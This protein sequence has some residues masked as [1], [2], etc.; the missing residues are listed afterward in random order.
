MRT[1]VR[2]GGEGGFTLVEVI[3]ALFVLAVVIL[4]IIFVQTR[5]LVTNADSQARQAAT[6]AANQAMEELRAMPWDYLRRGLYSGWNA[7]GSDPFVTGADA[8]RVDGVDYDLIVGTTGADQDPA[9]FA[10]PPLFDD[11]GA[12]VQTLSSGSGNGAEIVLR[13]YTTDDINGQSG[14]V[15]LLVVASWDKVSNG[16]PELTVITST[17]YSPTGGCGDPTQSPF[18]ASCQ[19]SFEASAQTANVEIAAL[20]NNLT[21]GDASPILDGSIFHFMHVETGSTAARVTSQQVSNTSAFATSGGV[22]WDDD[23]LST[24]PA[25][26]GW[27]NGYSQFSVRASDDTT[28][29]ADPANP[30]IVTGTG[31]AST[32]AISAAPFTLNARSDESRSASVFA[33]TTTSCA[34]GLLLDVTPTAPCASSSLGAN[35]SGTGYMA[36]DIDGSVL[37]LARI[38]ASGLYSRDN[39][40]AARFATVAGNSSVKCQVVTGTDSGCVSAGAQQSVGD[41]V[42][43]AG[44]WDAAG[45]TDGLI[46]IDGYS[47]SALA[48][49]GVG[50][51]SESTAPSQLSRS[52]SISYWDGSG[53]SPLGAVPAGATA[54]ED[55]AAATWTLPGATITATGGVQVTEGVTKEAVPLNCQGDAGCTVSASNGLVIATV[56]YEIEPAGSSTFTA[57]A[58]TVKTYINGS[59][60]TTAYREAPDAP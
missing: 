6:A 25:S 11:T 24:A 36:L 5:A 58:L 27:V 55:I 18:L 7:S 32:S 46:K 30:G 20:A 42:V 34:T 13:A 49:R 50:Y 29:G 43:G 3:V 35:A 14:A 38:D 48:Y 41:I 33:S 10:W 60:A 21:D 2:R 59:E 51:Q 31:A 26:Q 47:D 12:N 22:E 1:S 19:A 45:I 17:A 53:Y 56:T 16:N 52:A 15:G 57:W 37:T 54:A 28:A 23:V 40:W 44:D 9:S 39:A 4:A 8:I